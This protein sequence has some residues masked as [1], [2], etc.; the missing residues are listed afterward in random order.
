[1][2]SLI[3]LIL[4]YKYL[5]LFPLVVI[6]GPLVMMISGFLV[7]LGYLDFILTFLVLLIGD[8]FADVFWYGMGHWFGMSFIKKFGKFFNI[9][10]QGVEKV[11][12]IFLKYHSTI[13]FVSKVTIGLG[14]AL[15]TL[16]T[17]GLV[18]IPLRR[19][20]FWNA[21]GG[22]L[23][24]SGLMLIGFSLGNFY[25]KVDGILGKL[26]V[27]ALFVVVFIALVGIAKYMRHKFST[28][29]FL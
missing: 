8:L 22:L 2:T 12:N 19:F 4:A 18:K 9:T 5:I 6:E 25:L 7:K 10:E 17:A 14:F 20:T 15:V 26:S 28:K 11:K 13:L 29:D 24:T 3:S 23:L 21:L 27:L 16:V 1:M